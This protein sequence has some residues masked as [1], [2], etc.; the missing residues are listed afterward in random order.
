APPTVRRVRAAGITAVTEGAPGFERDGG[1]RAPY[2]LFMR[3]RRLARTLD[4]KDTVPAYL[5]FGQAADLPSGKPARSLAAVF[6][7]AHTTRWRYRGGTYVNE[8]SFAAAG[9]RF[10]PDTVLVLRVRVGDAGYLDPAGNRVPETKFT[11]SGAALLFHGG[12]VVRGTWSKTLDSGLSLRTPQGALTVPTGH[13]WI[14]LVPSNGGRV[15][16]G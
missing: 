6:S 4:A 12:R 1:R 10:K 3:L 8:N 7:P 14:E 5:P 11:G 13:T 9:D 2:N 15:E 16:I